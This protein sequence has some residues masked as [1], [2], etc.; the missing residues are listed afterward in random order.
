MNENKKLK[1]NNNNGVYRGYS[2][3]TRHPRV[4]IGVTVSLHD[5]HWVFIGVAH[6]MCV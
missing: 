5:T 4:F 3:V 1:N 2:V 6:Y